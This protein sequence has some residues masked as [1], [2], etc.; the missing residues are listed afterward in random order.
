MRIITSLAILTICLLLGTCSR[1]HRAAYVEYQPAPLPPQRAEPETV[2]P[3]QPPAKRFSAVSSVKVPS[4]RNPPVEAKPV[5][6]Q[7]APAPT[8]PKG[9]ETA[10]TE[11]QISRADTKPAPKGAPAAQ[12]PATI[13]A[14]FKAAQEKADRNGVHT[15]SQED[16]EGL[17]Y[18]Q[19]KA[20]RGY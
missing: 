13:E 6:V 19:I 16:I 5:K 1:P 2:K 10:P 17:S 8:P 18:E 15:L 14:R 20:L 9:A 12:S 7:A 4:P 11:T 3:G